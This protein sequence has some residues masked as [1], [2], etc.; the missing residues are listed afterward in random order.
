MIRLTI[1]NE[2][3]EVEAILRLLNSF[4]LSVDGKLS[5]LRGAEAWLLASDNIVY[6]A[7]RYNTKVNAAFEL[8]D[9]QST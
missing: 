9:P 8:A 1:T 3:K 2:N 5:T 4:D 7:P 6:G